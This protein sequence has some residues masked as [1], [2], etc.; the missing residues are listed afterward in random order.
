M[1]K[2][3]NIQGFKAKILISNWDPKLHVHS[4]VSL[5]DHIFISKIFYDNVLLYTIPNL[6]A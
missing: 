4:F 2:E 5:P 1:K 6:C 3:I